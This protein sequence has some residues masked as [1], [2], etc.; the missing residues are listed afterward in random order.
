MAR[1][2][3]LGCA[4][5]CGASLIATPAYACGGLIG[6]NGA[7]NLART[8]T[9]AAYHNGIEHYV[10][11]FTFTGA[12]KGTFGSI[13]PLPGIPTK[14]ER[15]GDWTL[16][17]LER[18]VAPPVPKGLFLDHTGVA[19]AAA[20]E[21]I[22]QTKIDALDITVLKGGAFA[23]GTWAEQHGF[24][25][26]PD[27]PSVLDFYAR[28]S[29]IFMAA[30]FDAAAAVKRGQ[31]AGDGTPIH[32]TIPTNNPWVPLRILAL[33]KQTSDVI[34]ADVFLLTDNTPAMLPAPVGARNLAGGPLAPGMQL[35]RSQRASGSLM[36]DLKIDK[37]MGWM[38]KSMWL[39]YIQLNVPAN[40]LGYDLAIDASGQNSPSPTAA[41][42]PSGLRAA[43]QHSLPLWL[44]WAAAGAFAGGMFSML[45][46][47]RVRPA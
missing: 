23:V 15:G 4:I 28:R 21:I 42:F 44:A 29:Q 46:R 37:G 19:F 30:R 32:L 27:A 33:G 45:L 7:V 40:A 10:T 18:E 35:V 31:R 36:K 47:R 11:A 1:R 8:T 43:V 22:L 16:Q 6:P 9:L 14:V 20:P 2:L 25:L 12:T 13:V 41:G 34:S 24:N 26:P 3:L 38:P 39:S 17:R 5:V